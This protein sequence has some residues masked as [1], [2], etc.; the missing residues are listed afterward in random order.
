MRFNSSSS[1][2]VHRIHSPP[3]FLQPQIFCGSDTVSS[4]TL[5]FQPRLMKAKRFGFRWGSVLQSMLWCLVTG[6]YRNTEHS[7]SVKIHTRNCGFSW[8]FLMNSPHVV[9]QYCSVDPRNWSWVRTDFL[10]RKIVQK[11]PTKPAICRWFFINF[12][13]S[14]QMFKKFCMCFRTWSG[15]RAPTTGILFKSS[16][17]ALNHL[18]HSKTSV[19]DTGSF[20]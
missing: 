11:D 15:W 14:G 20:L 18:N 4:D 10:L 16:H 13:V 2:Y 5:H 6:M 1:L 12:K 17:P 9:A 3:I 8:H 19:R 7:S